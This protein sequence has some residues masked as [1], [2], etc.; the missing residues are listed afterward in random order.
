MSWV[1]AL[2]VVGGADPSK[3]YMVHLDVHLAATNSG[4]MIHL[5]SIRQIASR[6]H[7][8]AARLTQQCSQTAAVARCAVIGSP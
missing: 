8:I 1:A 6:R 3:G 5:D 4:Y 2:I 7:N